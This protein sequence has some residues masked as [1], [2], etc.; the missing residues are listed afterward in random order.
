M[1]S[2]IL[3]ALAQHLLDTTDVCMTAGYSPFICGNLGSWSFARLWCSAGE[4]KF[5]GDAQE[6]L[7]Y[8][9]MANGM[10]TFFTFEE[11]QLTA[12]AKK[13]AQANKVLQRTQAERAAWLFFAADFAD[14]WGAETSIN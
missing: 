4:Y 1:I 3:R 13:N 2:K 6:F 14:E 10:F 7:A 11:W 12:R 5:C 9:G 8:L